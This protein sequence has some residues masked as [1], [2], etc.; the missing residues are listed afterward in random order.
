MGFGSKWAKPKQTTKHGTV[1]MCLQQDS[2]T[3]YLTCYSKS[4]NICLLLQNACKRGFFKY[5]EQN[6][7]EDLTKE[8]AGRDMDGYIMIP[9]G[10]RDLV[11]DDA[12]E[13]VNEELWGVL[14]LNFRRNVCKSENAGEG[15]GL[16]ASEK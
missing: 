15:N 6:K 5:M 8:A 9:N 7:D 10:L 4:K 13:Q 16:E 12:W 11:D 1:S 2:M 14:A 3:D